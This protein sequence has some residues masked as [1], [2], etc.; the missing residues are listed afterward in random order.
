MSIAEAGLV[1]LD[2]SILIRVLL[3]LPSV[4]EVGKLALTCRAARTKLLSPS[5]CNA[6]AR[7]FFHASDLMVNPYVGTLVLSLTLQNGGK[8][9]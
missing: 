3:H 4:V 9:G 8:H 7:H 2:E 6:L 5:L 1:E